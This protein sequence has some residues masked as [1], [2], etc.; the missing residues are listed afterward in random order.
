M[1][2]Q[3][4]HSATPAVTQTVGT[5]LDPPP[6]PIRL[7][8]APPPLVVPRP[9]D[10]CLPALIAVAVALPLALLPFLDLRNPNPTQHPTQP[11][12][13]S[14][15]PASASTLPGSAPHQISASTWLACFL[16][17]P[18][19]RPSLSPLVSLRR[20]SRLWSKGA[21]P[22]TGNPQVP[23]L[24]TATLSSILPRLFPP[25]L[26]CF[27]PSRHQHR[28]RRLS[29]SVPLLSIDF[30]IVAALQTPITTAIRPSAT[31]AALDPSAHLDLPSSLGPPP[32]SN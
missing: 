29:L 18:S 2:A 27:L 7:D 24:V 26:L 15:N 22:S 3:A 12:S 19:P 4:G 20:L 28:R 8:A 6:P 13:Y 32:A 17:R 25:R 23:P 1:A 11:S 30:D 16:P 9:P 10:A 21:T 31:T 14:H 5:L